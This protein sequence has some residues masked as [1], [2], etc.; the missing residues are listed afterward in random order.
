M[1]VSQDMLC[2]PD[3]PPNSGLAARAWSL[4]GFKGSTSS[5]GQS[6]VELQTLGFSQ[7]QYAATHRNK[8]TLRQ[9]RRPAH[10][11]CSIHFASKYVKNILLPLNFPSQL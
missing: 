2:A 6:P 9:T 11:V 10:A 3:L 7:S 5:P 4:S 8:P 1:F